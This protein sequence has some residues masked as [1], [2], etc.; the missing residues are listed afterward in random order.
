L[1]GE[2]ETPRPPHES[3]WSVWG[4]PVA[5]LLLGIV[6]VVA[7]MLLAVIVIVLIF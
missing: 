7:A 5:Y 3:W 6:G 2:D 1:S 4:K